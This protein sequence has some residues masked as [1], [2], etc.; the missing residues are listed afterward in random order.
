MSRPELIGCVMVLALVGCET[1]PGDLSGPGNPPGGQPLPP[2]CLTIDDVINIRPGDATGTED[3]G[4]YHAVTNFRESCTQC[5]QN[6]VPDATCTTVT[7]DPN[8]RTTYRQDGG[9]LT[10]QSTDGTTAQGGINDDGTFTLGA[11][12]TPTTDDG[13]PTGQ[14]LALLE[15]RFVGDRIVITLTVRMTVNSADGVIDLQSVHAV[16]QERVE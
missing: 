13:G 4:T 15:G 1:L 14:G 10:A 6:A 11:V 16:T 5:D 9:V 3:W 7:I 2:T 8:A 12:I